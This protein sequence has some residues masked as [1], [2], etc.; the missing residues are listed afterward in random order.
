[1]KSKGN[2]MRRKYFTQEQIDDVNRKEILAVARNLGLPLEKKHKEVRASGYGGLVLS[3]EKNQWVCF[4]SKLE[5]EK[6]YGG[7]PIQLVMYIKN[8]DFKEAVTYLLG[9]TQIED[10]K[11]RPVRKKEAIAFQL[12]KKASDFRHVYAYLIKTR[13]IDRWVVEDMVQKGLLY[14]NTYHSCVF[15]GKD[16]K[17]VPRH[18][19]IRGTVSNNAFRGEPSGS[20]KRYAFHKTGTSKILHVF[21]APIDLLSYLTIYPQT[22][23]DHHLALCCLADTALIEYVRH[24]LGIQTIMLHLDND[25]WGNEQTRKLCKKYETMYDVWDERPDR[26]WK[27]WNEALIAMRG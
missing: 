1:M 5:G 10:I 4:S 20:D 13:K 3:S 7:G 22:I 19:T 9:T 8:C 23:E 21:E 26:K 14:E 11:G 25:R 15:V 12:P 18:C 24:V 17:G 2:F 27:D 6:I 16:F